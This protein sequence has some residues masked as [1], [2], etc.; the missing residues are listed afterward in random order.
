MS[1]AKIYLRKNVRT[2]QWQNAEINTIL[3]QS[4]SN[5]NSYVTDII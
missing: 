1:L 3:V 2:K 5:K 4:R